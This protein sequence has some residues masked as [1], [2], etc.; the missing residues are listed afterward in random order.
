MSAAQMV[1][2]FKAKEFVDFLTKE[3]TLEI[4]NFAK[5]SNLWEVTGSNNFWD[6]RIINA[7]S[8]NQVS[9]KIGKILNDIKARIVLAAKDSYGISEG[10]YPDL[11]QVTR[12]YDGMQLTPHSDNMEGT[13]HEQFH[14]HRS[15]GVVIYL[16]NDYDGG[17]T[18]YPQHDY[19]V[20]PE[21]GKMAI[22]PADTNHMHGVTQISGNT[23]YTLTTFLTFDKNREMPNF[24]L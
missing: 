9:P 8:I 17:K 6:T 11:L 16:N 15:Y 24:I 23:R 12:W 13:D 2:S 21:P 4:L 5:S 19:E 3:E 22:H 7:F 20:N 14:K 1:D 10:I 18:F